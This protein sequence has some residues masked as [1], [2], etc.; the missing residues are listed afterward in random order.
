MDI[1]FRKVDCWSDDEYELK[2]ILLPVGMDLPSTVGG[3]AK[4]QSIS[5]RPQNYSTA[6][7]SPASPP[8]PRQARRQ[9]LQNPDLPQQRAPRASPAPTPSPSSSPAQQQPAAAPSTTAS[10]PSPAQQQQQQNLQDPT[11]QWALNALQNGGATATSSVYDGGNLGAGWSDASY[12]VQP[13]T[14]YTPAGA[15]GGVCMWGRGRAAR[16]SRTLEDACAC[17]LDV[18]AGKDR[19]VALCKVIPQGGAMALA[20]SAPGGAALTSK[21]FLGKK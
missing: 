2:P 21:P 14:G 16:C 3:S 17:A 13:F 6:A 11:A 10:G 12:S 15:P 9:L 5:V 18:R 1:S 8:S 7:A 4:T 20:W 19:G